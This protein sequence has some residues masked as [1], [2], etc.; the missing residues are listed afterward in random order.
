MARTPVK[1]D[2]TSHDFTRREFMRLSGAA[3]LGMATAGSLLIGS[4][5]VVHAASP[6]KGGVAR[7]AFNSTSP[8][9]T[10]DPIKVTS[11]IDATRCYQLYSNLVRA[12]SDQKP[13]PQIAETWEAD[14][15]ATEWVFKLRK[16]IVFHNG[17]KLTSA[18]V[19]YSIRRHLGEDT[20]S[21]I[22]AYM[23]QIAELKADGKYAIKIKLK[24]PNAELP[25]LFA[26]ARAG[27]V[28]DGHIDFDKPIGTGPFK[29]K[30]F[31]PGIRSLFVRHDDYFNVGNVH[32]DGI[33]TFAIP[34]PTAR[35]NALLSGEVDIAALIDA[36]SVPLI[37][38]SPNT[39]IVSSRG[40]QWVVTVP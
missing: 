20:E 3:G 31:Q 1:T 23:A 12:G 32:L 2:I 27:I 6:K 33:E 37:E 19:I 18:D 14:S 10:L 29:M 25:I 8:N 38:L 36:K 30:E 39:E 13:Y 7:V 21:K 5:S 15:S 40:G 11:N 22:K 9:D 28:P 24:D 34:D 16:D 26:S 17:K 35:A 4:S